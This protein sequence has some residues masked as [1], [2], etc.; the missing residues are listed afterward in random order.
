[1]AVILTF[2]HTVQ[3]LLALFQTSNEQ[4]EHVRLSIRG[5][6]KNVRSRHLLCAQGQS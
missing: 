3:D 1:M 2:V 6:L 4:P 5:C